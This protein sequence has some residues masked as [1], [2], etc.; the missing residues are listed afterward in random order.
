MRMNF[1]EYCR[2]REKARAPS[3]PGVLDG[4]NIETV[5]RDG[6]A[7]GVPLGDVHALPQST[8]PRLHTI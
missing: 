3:V 8:A 2:K 4:K 5:G 7:G 6:V 1:A